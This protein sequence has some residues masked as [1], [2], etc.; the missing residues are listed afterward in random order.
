MAATATHARQMNTMKAYV[1]PISGPNA[2]DQ[3]KA[4]PKA[5]NQPKAASAASPR[6]QLMKI[7]FAAMSDTAQA[8][9]IASMLG[10]SRGCGCSVFPS[11]RQAVV[12]LRGIVGLFV[13]HRAEIFFVRQVVCIEAEGERVGER[14]TRIGTD[15]C[16]TVLPDAPKGRIEIGVVLPASGN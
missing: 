13:F 15:H 11:D 3:R 2:Q 9:D 4:E 10:Y 16:V 6:R 1:T 7:R 12:Q 5:A 8:I 14:I